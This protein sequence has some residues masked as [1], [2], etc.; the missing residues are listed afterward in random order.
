MAAPASQGNTNGPITPNSTSITP[1]CTPDKS[2][3][4]TPI[5]PS[6]PSTSQPHISG[7][8]VVPLATSAIAGTTVPLSS[9]HSKEARRVSPNDDSRT[10]SAPS[11]SS[12]PSPNSV[13][14]S[15]TSGT[16][17]LTTATSSIATGPHTPQSRPSS[18]TSNGSAN[19]PHQNGPSSVIPHTSG[20]GQSSTATNMNGM[21]LPS[22]PSPVSSNGSANLAPN[23]SQ[24]QSPG[25]PQPKTPQISPPLQQQF[26]TQQQQQQSSQHS[27]YNHQSPL[28]NN[29]HLQQRNPHFSHHNHQ[30]PSRHQQNPLGPIT[31]PQQ[32]LGLI[33]GGIS[34]SSLGTPSA[35]M[36]RLFGEGPPPMHT[37]PPQPPINAFHPGFPPRPAHPGMQPMPMHNPINAIGPRMNIDDQDPSPE[38]ILFGKVTSTDRQIFN[39]IGPDISTAGSRQVASN[40]FESSTDTTNS[41]IDRPIMFRDTLD[42]IK[43]EPEAIMN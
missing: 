42:T 23:C 8:S 36:A 12:S 27:H 41:T 35:H 17:S 20:N 6:T 16:Q 10:G 25:N 40:P 15:S 31:A 29:S 11:T 26:K 32:M 33:A 21:V 24:A 9:P 7:S 18:V 3:N 38:A 2:G 22:L 39:Q 37:R 19:G 30:H 1:N 34:P 28:Y 4:S 14:S 43:S 5:P 13:S